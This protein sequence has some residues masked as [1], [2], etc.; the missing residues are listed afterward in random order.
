MNADLTAYDDR[1]PQVQDIHQT[2]GPDHE[3]STKGSSI[4]TARFAPELKTLTL[5]MKVQIAYKTL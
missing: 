2:P 3:I 5:I 4:G 1:L